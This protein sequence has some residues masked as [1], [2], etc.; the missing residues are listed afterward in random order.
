[1]KKIIV[2]YYYDFVEVKIGNETIIVSVEDL[3]EIQELLNFISK[4]LNIEIQ[5]RDCN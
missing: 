3:S 4:K 2:D 5:E 1:M